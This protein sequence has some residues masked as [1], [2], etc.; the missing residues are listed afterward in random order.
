MKIIII[1]EDIFSIRVFEY[2]INAGHH[3][4]EFVT[5]SYNKNWKKID[6]VSKRNSVKCNI[7]DDINNIQLIEYFKLLCPELILTVHFE[8]LLKSELI[9]IPAKGCINI[10]PSLLP[11]YKGLAP[12]HWPI[13]NGDLETG[14]TVHFIDEGMDTG[15]IILQKRISISPEESV[16]HLQL[17]M[18]ELYGPLVSEAIEKINL[19]DFI[20]IK[21][22]SSVGSYYPK[23]KRKDTEID[24]S[25]NKYDIYN[26]IRGVSYPYMG[27][28]YMK[29]IIWSAKYL[30]LDEE[31]SYLMQYPIPG[32]YKISD[33]EAILRVCDGVLLIDDYE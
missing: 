17:K 6:C 30:P 23:L 14:I 7:V 26:L 29:F 32:F 9:R 33:E 11:Y 15:E 18:L 16:S 2:L 19:D 5:P 21:N 22:D 10:H 4:L 31:A 20:P 28:H 25:K 27:A 1:G 13:I 3:I 12:Q 8:R 24:L